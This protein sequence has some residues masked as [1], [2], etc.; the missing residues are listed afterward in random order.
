MKIRTR[1]SKFLAIFCMICTLLTVAAY[2]APRSISDTWSVYKDSG[3]TYAYNS[4]C[5]LNAESNYYNQVTSNCTNYVSTPASSG[6]QAYVSFSGTGYNSMG[7]VVCNISNAPRQHQGRGT[8]RAGF[9]A[10]LPRYGYMS[11]LYSATNPSGL[12]FSIG[13]TVTLG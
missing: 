11:I 12:E 4:T 9:T 6:K 1:M 7:N 13:G 3:G 5:T 10:E 8:V 2:A